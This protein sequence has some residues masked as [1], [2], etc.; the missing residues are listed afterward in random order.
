MPEAPIVGA[1]EF[2]VKNKCQKWMIV[3]PF[4]V[5]FNPKKSASL[6]SV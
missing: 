6:C 1:A 3:F 2:D 4:F 5:M